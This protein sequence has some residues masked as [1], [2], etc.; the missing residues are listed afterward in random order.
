MAVRARTLDEPGELMFLDELR[1]SIHTLTLR[2]NRIT[3]RLLVR[4][5]AKIRTKAVA[6]ERLW[7]PE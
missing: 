5:A 7:D 3:H 4:C 2:F 1:I 6:T